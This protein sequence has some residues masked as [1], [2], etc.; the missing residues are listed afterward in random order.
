[1]SFKL[2][3]PQRTDVKGN[4]GKI[5]YIYEVHLILDDGL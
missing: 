3:N 1:M 4:W 5:T 2:T